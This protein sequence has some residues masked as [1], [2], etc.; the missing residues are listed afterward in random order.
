MLSLTYFPCLIFHF[1]LSLHMHL[2]VKLTSSLRLCFFLQ[3]MGDFNYPRLA[4]FGAAISGAN[5]LLC[6]E[7][8]EE[9]DVRVL[10]EAPLFLMFFFIFRVALHACI[11]LS[12]GHAMLLMFG[13]HNWDVCAQQ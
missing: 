8:L 10:L 7:V 9:L 4:D 2:N 6:Q 5:K 3:H 1:V 11:S 13:M 12:H